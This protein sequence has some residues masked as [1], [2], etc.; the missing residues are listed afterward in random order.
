MSVGTLQAL[1]STQLSYEHHEIWLERWWP[2]DTK[3]DH[4]VWAISS[5]GW[6]DWFS[7]HVLLH[8]Q[9]G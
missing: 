7:L 6:A 2:S 8:P 4:S 1:I 5:F 3:T 9:S